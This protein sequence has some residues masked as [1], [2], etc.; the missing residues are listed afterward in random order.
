MGALLSFLLLA[1]SATAQL[2]TEPERQALFVEANQ[3]FREANEVAATNPI[4]A[5]DLYRRSALRFERLVT[6]GGVRN[7]QLFYNIG[8]AYFRTNDVGRA[9]LN[10]RRAEQYIGDDPNLVQNLNHARGTRLDSFE[11]TQETQVLKTLLFW[12]YDIST[13]SRSMLFALLAAVFWTAAAVRLFRSEWA[14]AATADRD[15]PAGVAVSRLACGGGIGQGRPGVGGDPLAT[16][17]G[18]QRRRRIVRAQLQRT[19]P[20]RRG[21]LIGRRASRLVPH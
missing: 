16:S 5:D 15:R 7:G 3:L 1:I 9:I 11:E 13:G 12:H 6:V 10:Y 21:V 2:T 20:R 17:F 19:A 18:A 14:R 8:N 4:A